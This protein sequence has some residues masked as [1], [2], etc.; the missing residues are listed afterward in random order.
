MLPIR[1][2]YM[3]QYS[4]KIS[5]GELSIATTELSD[6]DAAWHEAVQTVRDIEATLHPGGRCDP[7]RRA[8]FPHRCLRSEARLKVGLKVEIEGI[9]SGQ[10]TQPLRIENV[11]L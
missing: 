2:A 7:R 9:E 5:N 4:F 3:A 8:T 10:F 6:D 11:K 1:F